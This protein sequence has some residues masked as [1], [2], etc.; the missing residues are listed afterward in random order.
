VHLTK[1]TITAITPEAITIA[2]D[3][4]PSLEWGAMTMSFQPPAKGLPPGLT[5][6]DPVS[7]SFA[8]AG[9]SGY[10]IDSITVLNEPATDSRP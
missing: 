10:R 6:G 4:V 5:V 8:S 3:P 1:G 2:H 9:Q 7:F